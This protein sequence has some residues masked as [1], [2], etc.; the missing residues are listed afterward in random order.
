M[1]QVA[2]IYPFFVQIMN[3][4]TPSKQSDT[5]LGRIVS[6]SSAP[7]CIPLITFL[8]LFAMDAPDTM[9]AVDFLLLTIL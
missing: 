9:D 3:L 8:A 4:T 6:S 5:P 7:R 1:A 2:T